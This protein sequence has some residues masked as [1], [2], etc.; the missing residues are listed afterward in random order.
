M[1]NDFT[2]LEKVKNENDWNAF[3][4]LFSRF[5]Q[6]LYLYALG[7]VKNRPEA[8]DIV[9]NAFIQLWEKRAS[10]NISDNFSG[11]IHRVVRNA[12][13]DILEHRKVENRYAEHVDKELITHPEYSEH[14]ERIILLQKAIDKLPTQ[15][16]EFFIMGCIEGLSYQDI[17]NKKGVSINTVKTQIKIGYKKI[18][19]DIGCNTLIICALINTIHNLSD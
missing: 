13:F 1:E 12:G 2:L 3:K 11:Y 16:R 19:E 7:I 15:C 17:A 9:Q 5:N 14:D 18:K 8:E 4:E 10:V 6:Q